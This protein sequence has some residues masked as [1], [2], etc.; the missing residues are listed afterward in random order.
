MEDTHID[1]VSDH[2]Q[3]ERGMDDAKTYKC[4]KLKPMT[5]T[6]ARE[7]MFPISKLTQRHAGPGVNV[8]FKIGRDSVSII[9]VSML[10]E[11][12]DYM[13]KPKKRVVI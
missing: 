2:S 7:Y 4:S 11:A 3:V 8:A 10:D 9:E 1:I 12:Q 13:Y 5:Y 6:T